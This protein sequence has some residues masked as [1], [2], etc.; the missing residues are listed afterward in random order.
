MPAKKKPSK[1]SD[2]QGER[3]K[4]LQE[5][6]PTYTDASK[7]GKTRLI[8]VSFFKKYWE[9]FPWR[10]PLTQD[11]DRNNPTDYALKPQNPEEEDQKAN[12]LREIEGASLLHCLRKI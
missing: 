11:P 3:A 4:L 5:F 8:W 6:Y 7:H 9:M 2:F 10:L 1:P 12:T